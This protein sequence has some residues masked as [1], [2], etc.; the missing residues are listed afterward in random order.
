[1]RA[2]NPEN[3]RLFWLP[4][5]CT[6]GSILLLVLVGILVA[7]VFALASVPGPDAFVLNFG[8]SLL[9]IEWIVLISAAL[10]CG[11]RRLSQR[12]GP[13]VVAG[14]TV[15]VIPLVTLFASGLVVGFVRAESAPAGWFLIRNV[16]ISLL[17]SLM[18]LRYL[19]LHNQWRQQV[20]AEASARLEAL[21]A[22]IRP[23]FLFN[24]LNTIASLVHEK[25]DAAEQATLDLS[26][27]LRTG[28][29]SGARHSLGEE[30]EL[31]RGYLR[32]ESLRLGE[33]L[34]VDW[35]LA[36]DLPLDLELPALLI[37]P[38]VENALVHGIARRPEGGQVSIHGQRISR[39]RL[40]FEITNPLA[41]HNARP[42]ESNRLALDNIRQR[43]ALAFEEGAGLKTRR[44]KTT[45]RA[46]L[47]LPE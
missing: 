46:E 43:L 22:S 31:V 3:R 12:L 42:A 16:L 39:G 2:S 45:F 32:L 21:Q 10:L 20:A 36:D 1:M 33:R 14:L 13:L 9:F 25:P 5:L 24:A 17:A 4:D 37:Q 35:Q 29:R 19:V 26:D 11:L 41:E 47:T 30:L 34:E 44:D 28:L 18:L 27:L 23:H 8:M 7:L 15:A 6:P 38:L 40:R